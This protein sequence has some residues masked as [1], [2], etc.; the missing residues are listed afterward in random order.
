MSLEAFAR[1]NAAPPTYSTI[2]FSRQLNRGHEA[3]KPEGILL[4]RWFRKNGN[5]S[6]VLCLRTGLCAAIVSDSIL[7]SEV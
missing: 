5:A 3:T 7:N 2:E 4:S 1:T 6:I